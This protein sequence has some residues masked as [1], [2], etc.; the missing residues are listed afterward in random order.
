MRTLHIRL[1]L[2]KPKTSFAIESKTKDG[3]LIIRG[4]SPFD[5]A[6]TSTQRLIYGVVLGSLTLDRVGHSRATSQGGGE[7]RNQ[8]GLTAG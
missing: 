2:D 5:I 1:V 4:A 6:G 8:A 7:V 3:F